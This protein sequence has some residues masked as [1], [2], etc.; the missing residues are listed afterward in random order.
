MLVYHSL[1]INCC[2]ALC[3]FGTSFIMYYLV[4]FLVLIIL[5]VPRI[6][7]SLSSHTHLFLYA[8]DTWAK[9]QNIQNPE[10]KKFKYFKFKMSIVLRYIEKD[11]EN[12]IIF[13]KFST[14]KPV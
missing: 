11:S 9:V 1:N 4:S 14:V 8:T 10:L 3:V 2:S 6:G 12:I 5:A 13:A 7:L